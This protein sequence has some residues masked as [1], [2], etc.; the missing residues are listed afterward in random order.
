[1]K[2]QAHTILISFVVLFFFFHCSKKNPLNTE[3]ILGQDYFPTEAGRF[4]EYDID[5]TVYNELLNSSVLYQYRIKEKFTGTF[6]D[7]EGRTCWRLERYIKK[8]NPSKPYDSIPY[9]I[10]E[11]W[12]C[13]KNDKLVEQTEKNVPYIKLIFPVQK[14]ASWNG[15]AKNNIGEEKFRYVE[16]DQTEMINNITLDNVLTVQQ[17]NYENLLNKNFFQEKYAR[18]IG[19]VYKEMIS[20]YSSTLNPQIPLM[21]R[22]S[23]GY[24]YKQSI[25]RY[26]KE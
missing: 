13:F 16:V 20:V 1:M 15:N 19:L 7:N 2:M 4:V 24:V 10:K 21:Q 18:G 5:S 11:V 26:G 23:G 17:K 8:K 25:V 12:K 14:D 9:T 3:A 22:V 6:T